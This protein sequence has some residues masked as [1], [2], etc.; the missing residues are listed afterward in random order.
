MKRLIMWINYYKN[1]IK[2]I[3]NVI[4]D[5]ITI[6][7]VMVNNVIEYINTPTN[8]LILVNCIDI[9]NENNKTKMDFIYINQENDN[10]NN[11]NKKTK[12]DF[13]YIN[14]EN[15]NNNK[16]NQN[17]INKSELVCKQ[18]INRPIWEK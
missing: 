4:M 7:T 6:I 9:N 14:Q 1:Y 13:I 12:R 8:L 18:T 5:K 3:R 17:K 16:E 10:N 15:N 11:D 2:T